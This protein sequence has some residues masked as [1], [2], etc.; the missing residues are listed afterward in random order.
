MELE[1]REWDTSETFLS[2]F[3]SLIGDERTR[4][5]FQ[6]VIHGIISGESLRA[7]VIAR[8]FP[9]AMAAISNGER[10]VR[11]MAAG[12]STQRSRLDADQ[13]TNI[14]REQGVANLRAEPELE[15]VLDG[16]ELR[17]PGAHEQEYLMSVKAL[18]GSLVN[19]YRSFNLG[20][21]LEQPEVR[22]LAYLGSWEERKNRPP[23]KQVLT[24][25]LRRLIDQATTEAILRK[26]IEE[27]GDLPPFIKRLLASYGYERRP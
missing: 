17:R 26:H 6:G 2:A 20:L 22:L 1:Q 18:D 16:M 23:G 24:R 21:T 14:L 27:Y 13:V 25:G 9:P 10:R 5:T 7:A 4:R 19:G 3:D 15:L 12:D 8:F 11:R